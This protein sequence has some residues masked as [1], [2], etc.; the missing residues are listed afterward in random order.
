MNRPTRAAATM[1]A[2]V[3]LVGSVSVPASADDF[4]GCYGPDGAEGCVPDNFEHTFCFESNMTSA[5]IYHSRNAM[6]YLGAYSS[7]Y[8]NEQSSCGTATD[9]VFRQSSGTPSAYADYQCLDWNFWGRCE[10]ARIRLDAADL[11]TSATRRHSACHEI[12]HSGGLRHGGTVDCMRT[13]LRSE[14]NYSSHH[15]GHLNNRN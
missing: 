10:Q 11:T 7:Y 5:F 8:D 1:V 9:I 3:I 14:S 6:V 15:I 13:G 12:G 4:G 2:A